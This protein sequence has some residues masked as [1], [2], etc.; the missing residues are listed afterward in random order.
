M[1]KLLSAA[2]AIVSTIGVGHMQEL[3]TTR[4]VSRDAATVT[5]WLPPRTADG[6]PDMQ[7]F[8]TFVAAESFPQGSLEGI[9]DPAWRAD[10]RP[11][12]Y[13][14]V[15]IDPID[16]R[17]PY[18]TWAQEKKNDNFAHHLR[19]TKLQYIDGRTRCHLPGVPRDTYSG[20]A[21]AGVV[22]QI[23]QT[24]TYVV[25]TIEYVHAFRII[26]LDGRPHV[27]KN[28][29]LWQGDSRGHWEDSTLVIDTTNSNGKW[30]DVSGDFHSDALHTVERWTLIDADTLRVDVTMEDPKVYTRP[31]KMAFTFT[32]NLEKDYETI[33]YACV[34]G[35]RDAK[36]ML[37]GNSQ[38][39]LVR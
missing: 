8:W 28:V 13:T 32:R 6:Q 33:E 37:L 4:A 17:I 10:G 9:M 34:E 15:I 19:P 31:W 3:P 36:Q 35:E 26:P 20:A 1:R 39:E 2:V 11:R 29:Q 22:R 12:K 5:N 21:E 30:L 16:G 24:P 25:M 27:H 14:S 18:Q 7:G 38:P 23:I